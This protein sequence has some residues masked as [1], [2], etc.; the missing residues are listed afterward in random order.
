MHAGR[1]VDEIHDLTKIDKWFLRKLE[2]IVDMEKI[3]VY[4]SRCVLSPLLR[5]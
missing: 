1:S 5:S 3:L 4:V 2:H